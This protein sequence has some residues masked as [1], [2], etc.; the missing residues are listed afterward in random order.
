MALASNALTTVAAVKTYMGVS[1]STDDDLIETMV[2]NVSDQIERWC[3]RTFAVQTYTEYIDARGTRTIA[4]ENPPVESVDIVAFGAQDSI[5]V[6]GSVATDLVATVGVEEDRVRLHRIQEDGTTTTTN[7]LFSSYA[8]TAL[9]SAAIDG[10]AGFDSSSVKNAPV[11]TLHRIG[12]RD[13]TV[14]TAYLSVADDM[15]S[16]YRIDYDRGLIHLRSDAFPRF[17]E[18]RRDNRFPNQ[19]Q[20][21]FIQ[22]EGGYTTIP[23]ALVQAAF[24]LISDAY[25][26]RDRDRAINQ[27]SLGDYSYTVRPWAEWNENVKTLLAPFK[28]IR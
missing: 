7:L 26:G 18:H 10:T 2:N 4:V 15:E 14:A 24:E 11:K 27:E 5:L 21:V 19:F 25:R 17:A 1:T 12:G 22:Y 16:E 28:R 23:N 8:T 13:T 3:D 6:T 9:L 20:S